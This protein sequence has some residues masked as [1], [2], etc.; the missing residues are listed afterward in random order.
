MSFFKKIFNVFRNDSYASALKPSRKGVGEAPKITFKKQI[1]C[2]LKDAAVRSFVDVLAM[3]A[4]GMGF[5][6][7]C[8]PENEYADAAKAKE[9]VDDFNERNNIDDLLQ[10]TARELVATGNA[11]WQLFTP[12]KIETVKRVPIESFERIITNEFLGFEETEWT[13]K[14]GLQLGFKQ[15]SEYGG[16]L[17]SP[18]KLLHF[19]WN[20]IDASGWGVGVIYVLLSEYSWQEYDPNTQQYITRTCPSLFT[21]KKKLDTDLIEIFEKHAGPIEA[22]IAESKAAAQKLESE[23]KTTPKYGGK[24]VTTGK[25][26]IKTPPLEARSRFESYVE[27][28][29][30]Q[31]CLGGE[32]PLPKLFTTPGFTEASARAAIDIADRLVLPLQRLIKRQLEALWRKVIMHANPSLDPVKASVRLNWGAPEVPELKIE[33]IINLASI[34]AQTGVQYIRPEEVRKN[35]AKFGVELWEPEQQTIQQPQTVTE[36]V[37]EKKGEVWL[38]KKLPQ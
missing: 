34:S 14:N 9:I 29:W 30:N 20:P 15:T 7:T 28:L 38:I 11:V 1:E 33:H 17:I 16:K 3:Q 18:E 35:L 21:I 31:F 8:A 19:R 4:V 27:Y 10:V 26:E 22:W 37:F 32:T 12:D 13:R 24:L 25:L 36:K 5:Y 23:L 2:Y 6:T